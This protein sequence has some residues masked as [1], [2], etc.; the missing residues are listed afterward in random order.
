MTWNVL[1]DDDFAREFGQFE[2]DVKIELRALISLL[3]VHG[4]KLG[5]P[6]ADTLN[7][8]RY[9]N[10]KELRFRAADGVWRAAFA[11][12]P[13]RKAI[14]LV[15]GDKSGSSEKNFYR[16]LI[17]TAD[18]RYEAHLGSLNSKESK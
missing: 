12:D 1:F 14:V 9:T 15:A 10:M 3:V 5:S 6:W 17:R 18:Q 4:P 2:P 16:R 13:G 7:G 8:S 11:F